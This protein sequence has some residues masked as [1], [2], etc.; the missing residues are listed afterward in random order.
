VW[1]FFIF[2]S[3]KIRVSPTGV[4]SSLFPP[5]CRLSSGRCHHIAAPC[6]ASVPLN[7]D[8]LVVSA[9]SFGNASSHR[10]LSRAETE[11]LNPHDQ[12]RSPSTIHYYKKIISTV[13][14]PPTT[15]SHLHF[16]SSLV[17]ASCHRSSIRRHHFLSSLSHTHH[18]ST[19]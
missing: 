6:H 16:V 5:W 3:S 10:I 2:R 12:S 4:V 18:P 15:Q 9:S 19:Q 13:A 7:Q 17:R 14:T 11:A 1:I 8:E